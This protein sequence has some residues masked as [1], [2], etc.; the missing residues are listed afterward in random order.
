MMGKR[1]PKILLYT[2]TVQLGGAENH[3]LN[4]LKFYDHES[5][6]LQLACSS[7]P[8]LDSWCQK[9]EGLGI[10][11]YRLRATHK[12]DPRHYT[13]LVKILKNED[14]DVLHIHL[15]NP[16]SGRYGILA[17]KKT[18]IPF[19]ITEHDPFPLPA[20][21]GWLKSKLIQG[22]SKTITVSQKNKELLCGLYP[23]LE[24]RITMIHNG[25][26]TTWFESQLLS[27][28]KS[29]R[30]EMRKD[31]FHTDGSTP[32]ITCVAELHPRK[33][34][35]YL[36]YAAE[37]LAKKRENIKII[38]VGSGQEMETYQHFIR[39]YQLE[40]YVLLLGRRHDIP[41]IL[42]SSDIF[43]LP[44]L[45]EAFGL[46]LLEAMMAG[47]PIIATQN[48]GVPEIIE[49]QK[50]GLLIPDQS[51]E[52]IVAALQKLLA[53]PELCQE[54]SEK[55]QKDVKDTFDVKSMVKKTEEVYRDVLHI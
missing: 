26:D 31:V 23:F 41:Q 22:V 8:D 21:K 16:A 43:I 13:E 39:S 18:R 6:E 45:N 12:H 35:H 19:I 7:H 44:S 11:V 25:I 17:A 14:I 47:L 54:M 20:V 38:I 27:F 42:K 28:S 10:K 50:N 24:D 3:M 48:G 46:V 32:I 49:H 33:G 51:D 30:E 4:L 34:I 37:N 2:D 53:T 40:E 52:A 29:D 5:A 36:L 1:K 15:W 9:I 55:N